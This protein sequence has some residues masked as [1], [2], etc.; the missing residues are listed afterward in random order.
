M[1]VDLFGFLS[2]CYLFFKY[3]VSFDGHMT[4]MQETRTL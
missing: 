3:G 2:H 1:F 4:N